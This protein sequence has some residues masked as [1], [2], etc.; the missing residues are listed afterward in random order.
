MK[1]E[2]NLASVCSAQDDIKESVILG[3][4]YGELRTSGGAASVYTYELKTNYGSGCEAQNTSDSF[5]LSY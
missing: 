5:D 4:P 1:T 2:V 3:V